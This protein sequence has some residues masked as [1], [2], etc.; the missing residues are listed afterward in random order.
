VTG[1]G[2]TV[3]NALGF[4]QPSQY[5]EHRDL[6]RLPDEVWQ[7]ADDLNWPYGRIASLRRNSLGDEKQFIQL[8]INKARNQGYITGIAIEDSPAPPEPKRKEVLNPLVATEYKEIF[9][10]LWKLAGKVGEGDTRTLQTDLNYVRNMKKWLDDL[11][12]VIRDNLAK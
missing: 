5:R 6:L 9:N 4:K 7:L 11:E 12:K 10:A 1:Y 8:A 2:E 3:L